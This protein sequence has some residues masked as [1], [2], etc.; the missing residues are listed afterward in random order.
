MPP[1]LSDAQERTD[2]TI[3][4]LFERYNQLPDAAKA[5]GAG[6][7]IR[8]QI[9]D[10]ARQR[11]G[12]AAADSIGAAL[13]RNAVPYTGPVQRELWDST[14]PRV[15]VG[16]A[17]AG[18]SYVGGGGQFGAAPAPRAVSSPVYN[19][20]PGDGRLWLPGNTTLPALNQSDTAALNTR[21]AAIEALNQGNFTVDPALAWQPDGAS[22]PTTG[23]NIST[24]GGTYDLAKELVSK[25]EL[26]VEKLRD[27]FAAGGAEQLISHQHE[28]I[29]T[30]L[31]ALSASATASRELPGLIARG[32]TAANDAFH[33]LRG[34]ALNIRQHMSDTVTE[35]HSAAAQL[36][37]NATGF[38]ITTRS[39][40]SNGAFENLPQ[41]STPASL[42][43]AAQA[44]QQISGLAA[45]ISAPDTVTRED[46]T[47]TGGE[48]AAATETSTAAL[49]S[50]GSA[51]AAG[52]PRA[53]VPGGGAG[54]GAS[55]TA[56]K[57]GKDD[58]AK[59]LS[60]LGSQV[61]SPVPQAAIMPQQAAQAAQ[62]AAKP[63]TDAAEQ[64]AQLPESVL[65]A[66]RGADKAANERAL[67]GDTPAARAAEDDRTAATTAAFTAPG[68]AAPSQLGLP[69][70]D[71]RPNQLDGHGKPAD[72]DGN[73]KVDKDAVPLS[74]KTVKPFDLSVPAD[75]QNIQVKGITDPRLGEM[76]LNM[77]H[78]G[79]GGAPMSVLEA[80]QAAGVD[81]EALGDP[82]EASAVA[83]GDAVIG[84]VQSGIYLGEGLVLTSTG[85]IESLAD[86]LG[87]DG[88]VSEIPL[89][90]LPDDVPPAL[91]EHDG[92]GGP[93]P[94]ETVQVS[95]A[96]APTDSPAPASAPDA[97]LPPPPAAE[98]TVA[99]A[100]PPPVQPEPAPAPGPAE[101]AA[102]LSAPAAV[103][104]SSSGDSAL[105]K[106]VPFEGRALG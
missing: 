57:A 22:L 64:V 69:G 2:E 66:L 53:A 11:S 106:A 58:L 47:A 74:K 71:A 59:L 41:V 77:A 56:G 67:G 89:P 62:K 98:P 49:P 88:F 85:L 44:G 5:S 9:V 6:K 18:P 55:S 3:D 23:T 86:V 87:E 81:I 36:T 99:P 63:L 54:A 39:I 48:S 51:P 95:P 31:A 10:L 25:W 43:T 70:S 40:V 8:D 75:G 20:P 80:A 35:M 94:T 84:A 21:D 91:P 32:G 12:D 76:M 13:D 4:Q 33:E 83:V 15:D 61:A 1:R 78:G 90:E 26:A 14:A 104:A 93:G 68:P 60:S 46:V 34:E 101:G 100:D 102:P 17:S 27:A 30:P 82:L 38:P 7:A 16:E 19:A 42:A 65:D 97:A 79:T 96:S 73:G 37:Q 103:N 29:R 50:S 105:P 52:S 28:R 24:L 72:K 92:G 45:R